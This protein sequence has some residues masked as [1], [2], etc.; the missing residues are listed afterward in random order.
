MKTFDNNFWKIFVPFSIF[1]IIILFFPYLFTSLSFLDINFTKTGEIGDTIGGIL[2]PF[3][4]LAAAVLTFFAFWVQ[5]KANEQQKIDLRIER[6]ENKFYELLRLHKSNIEELQIGD[7]SGRKTFVQMFY[8][9]K[10]CYQLCEKISKR[11]Y[12]ELSDNDIM[13][14]TY[15]IFFYGIGENSEKYFSGTFSEIKQNAFE[16]IKNGLHS[17]QNDYSIK[18]KKLDNPINCTYQLK[19]EELNMEFY[20]SPF[21]GHVSHL[22]HYFIHL[23][24][25]ANYIIKQDDS[26]LSQ[27]QKYDYIKMLRSQL[28]NFEQLLMYYNSVAWFDEEWRHIFTEYKLIKNIPLPLADFYISPKIHYKKEIDES[29]KKGEEIFNWQ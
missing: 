1:I 13:D 28:S 19:R 5:F 17:I 25:T 24:Q 7:L 29:L 23:F 18:K 20:Y 21:N 8:E 10:D 16:K 26:L 2:T 22:S 27:E 15:S 12:I 4:A 6:F 3:I 11:N 9:L 14:I